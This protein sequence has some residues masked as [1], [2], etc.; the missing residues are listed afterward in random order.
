MQWIYPLICFILFGEGVMPEIVLEQQEKVVTVL[1]GGISTLK[2]SMT[3]GHMHSYYMYWYRK[4]QD[5]TLTFICDENF[6][7]MENFQ[8][9][10]DSANNKF[11][12]KIIKPSVRD[13]GIYYC[14][15]H[16]HSA[17]APLLSN[18]ETYSQRTPRRAL[19]LPEELKGK[20][21]ADLPTTCSQG[22]SMGFHLT[23]TVILS[24]YKGVW[25]QI[26]LE[27]SGNEIKEIGQFV[28]L[29]C[30]V[31]GIQIENAFMYWYRQ[32]KVGVG[33]TRSKPSC[34]GVDAKTAMLTRKE[35]FLCWDCRQCNALIFGKGTHL[36]VVPELQEPSTPS[37][38]VMKNG[39]NVACLV[40]DFY[41]K[42]VDIHLDPDNNTT[43]GVVTTANGK[44][45]A[46]KL[47]Q[48]K[49]D[50]EQIKCTVRH[51][52]KTVEASYKKSHEDSTDKSSDLEEP[53]GQPSSSQECLK[54]TVQIEKV[55]LL[56]ITLLGLR[57][58]LAKSIA[59]NFF[60][61]IKCFLL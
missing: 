56:S 28:R 20:W 12:L 1:I 6:C 49:K 61:T 23:L 33:I 37:V 22:I 24:L 19:L 44:F 45:S 55:N 57:V 7:D 48:Y 4:N 58:L 13:N 53:I 39:T 27:Q 46:V 25:A 59:V 2:C 8:S 50:L 30:K 38:F 3:G 40:K 36:E 42:P 10:I 34:L 17:S 35:R 52:N 5:N 54:S 9:E 43:E 31:S 11:T 60:L 47:G 51:N 32:Q 18:S 16:H 29:S 15:A 41:P 14:A 21:W 26:K